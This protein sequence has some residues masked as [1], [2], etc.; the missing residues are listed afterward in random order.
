MK[1]N[2]LISIIIPTFNRA[3]L[4]GETLDS[5]CAQTFTNWECIVVDD[6]STDATDEF[7]KKYC[8]KDNRFQY[9]KRPTDRKKGANT[10]RNIGLDNAKG[11]YIVF[12]DSD[13]LMTPDHLQVKY[14]TISQSD[15]DY[16]ITRTKFF[17]SDSNYIDSYYQFHKYK[18]TPYNYIVQNI[19]WLTYDCMLKS[20]IAKS[21]TFNEKLQSGQ[22]YNYFSKLVHLSVNAKFIDKIVTLRRYHV[23]S[24]RGMLK[25][26]RKL[27]ESLID[28]AWETYKDLLGIANKSSLRFLLRKVMVLTIRIEKLVIADKFFFLKQVYKNYG[29]R[30][31]YFVLTLAVYKH[32]G[33]GYSLEKRWKNY[34][35]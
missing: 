24:I 10:C 7:L 6:S 8:E 3:H 19:N 25:Q 32:T 9:L 12:F 13:D 22:E 31:V 21:I 20:H 30:T 23:K 18:I 28:S 2:T 1:K 11:K 34:G 29:Y 26:N 4:I 33:R 17:N 35:I 15:Y 5:I 16:V 14:E 27:E